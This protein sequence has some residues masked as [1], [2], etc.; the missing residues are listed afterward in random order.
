MEL[1]KGRIFFMHD[2]FGVW[3]C[4]EECVKN[5]CK[6][7]L[8]CFRLEFVFNVMANRGYHHQIVRSCKQK[9][10]SNW[11][12]CTLITYLK[13]YAQN[14]IWWCH[15]SNSHSKFT[16]VFLPSNWFYHHEV[17]L[18]RNIYPLS[19]LWSWN[20]RVT[21]NHLEAQGALI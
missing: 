6:T 18:K 5:I 12:N 1:G 20:T 16:H 13:L 10:W 7:S 4:G 19:Y 21:I 8:Q 17:I 3:E 14:P 2:L 15:L 9:S 11:R